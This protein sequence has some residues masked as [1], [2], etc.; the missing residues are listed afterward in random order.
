MSSQIKQK[1]VSRREF[2]ELS[3]KAAAAAAVS[4]LASPS[5]TLG[6]DPM[7]NPVRVAHIGMG[8]RGGRLL[9]YTSSIPSAK[10]VAICDVYK[11]HM[12]KGVYGA[13]NPE[14]K[15]YHDYRDLLDDPEIEAVVIACPDHWHE[16]MLIDAVKTGKDV[17]CEK[18]WTTSVSAAKRMRAAVKKYGRVMQLGHQGRQYAAAD[19]ARKMIEDGALGDITLIKIG[20][21]FN[22]TADRPAWRWYGDYSN[23]VKPD[24]K[25]VIKDLDWKRWLGSSKR[26]DFNERHFW[27]WRC[28]WEYGTGQAGD[29][30]SHETD[31]IQSITTFGI[32]SH[33]NCSGLNA[34][35]KDDREVPDTW[36]STYQWD[37]KNCTMLFEGSQNSKRMQTPEFV[38]RDARMIFNNIGQSASRFEVYADDRA[39]VPSQYPQPQPTF[40]FAAGK[41]HRKPSHM[42]NFLQCV[43]TREKAWCNEDE[44]FI[45][46]VTMLMSVESY[47]KRRQVRWDPRRERIV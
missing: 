47:K 9:Q 13:N 6:S 4:T 10:V 19:V 23:Y 17:Y 31:F 43:R 22:G 20:R 28:Y 40:T 45:E 14:V 18:G 16:K 21:Y 39:Y 5:L 8:V 26:I 7:A 24:A 12:Q 3:G 35:W 46:A 34:F 27:H 15:S 41:E 38:G 30:L 29:L 11:P 33:C 25:Q 2:I 1:M 32:P 42:E 36:M 37:D 44:A